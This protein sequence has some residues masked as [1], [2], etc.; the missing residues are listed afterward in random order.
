MTINIIKPADAPP[1]SLDAREGLSWIDGDGDLNILVR[2][3]AK[4][5][6]RLCFAPALSGVGG[7]PRVIDRE[8]KDGDPMV[9]NGLKSA[10]QL[11]DIDIVIRS[12]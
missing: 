5:L 6:I 2:N 4:G 8:I 7:W 1:P 10:D 11:V 9:S 12:R 3:G